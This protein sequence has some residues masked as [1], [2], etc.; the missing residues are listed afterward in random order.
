[1]NTTQ[2]PCRECKKRPR[3]EKWGSY[4]NKCARKLG[5]Y[6]TRRDFGETD[7]ILTNNKEHS[8]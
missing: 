1:M 6:E 7:R 5:V 2:K 4:C 8:N 3:V